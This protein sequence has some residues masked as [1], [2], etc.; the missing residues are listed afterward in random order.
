VRTAGASFHSRP[1]RVASPWQAFMP[2]TLKSVSIGQ[3]VGWVESSRPTNSAADGGPRRL[4]P[5]Y[6]DR[7]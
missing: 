7:L 3:L 5:P 4:G 1:L 6:C 2:G